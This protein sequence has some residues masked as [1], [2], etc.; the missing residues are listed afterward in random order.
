MDPFEYAKTLDSRLSLFEKL[1]DK[2]TGID[3]RLDVTNRILLE[4]LAAQSQ[5][6]KM[7]YGDTHGEPPY[8]IRKVDLTTGYTTT[9]PYELKVSGSSI[10]FFTTG[11]LNTIQ[12]TTDDPTRDWLPLNELGN[13]FTPAKPFE[14]VFLAWDAQPEKYLRVFIGR[15][16]SI[17]GG[18]TAGPGLQYVASKTRSSFYYLQTAIGVA[19]TQ[20]TNVYNELWFGL[21][22]KADD[23][24]A[25]SIY[26]GDATVTTLTGFR[27]TAGQGM[28][29]EVDSASRIYG[30]ASIPAQ[31]LY[32]IGI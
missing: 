6:M 26:I 17:G 30:I 12:F 20:V 29:M 32:Y 7:M 4:M 11:Q 8:N 14:K 3:D 18:G 19:A 13:P 2:A 28:V 15:G 25:G 16:T 27:L 23:D 21:V 1:T 9:S 10:T 31:K 24:N 22:L 5:S